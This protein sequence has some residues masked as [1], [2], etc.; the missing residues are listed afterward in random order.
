[1]LET[2]VVKRAQSFKDN[3]YGVEQV[4]CGETLCLFVELHVFGQDFGGEVYNMW[5][6]DIIVAVEIFYW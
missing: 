2:I 6:V 5:V 1:M 4:S 3:N